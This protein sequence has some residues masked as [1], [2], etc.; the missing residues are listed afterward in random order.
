LE[1]DPTDTDALVLD[2]SALVAI[3]LNEPGFSDLAA[4]VSDAETVI[5]GAPT[6]FETAMVLQRKVGGTTDLMAFLRVAEAEIVS[7]GEEHH[8]AALNAF[9][10]FGKGRHPARLNI[11][12]CMSYAVAFIAGLPLLYTGDD[13]SKTDIEAA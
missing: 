6:L 11:L 2:S 9:I 7:F 4:K 5:V 1:S 8:T 3:L 12:G 13:F 10:R